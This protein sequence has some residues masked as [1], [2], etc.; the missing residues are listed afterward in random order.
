MLLGPTPNIAARC[1][2]RA[3]RARTRRTARWVSIA[4]ASGIARRASTSL[5]S[6]VGARVS[7]MPEFGSSA[8][9]YPLDPTSGRGWMRTDRRSESR[10]APVGARARSTVLVRPWPC[11][12][13]VGPIR[14]RHSTCPPLW[15]ANDPALTH[16]LGSASG[17]GRPVGRNALPSAQRPRARLRCSRR[18]RTVPKH[19]TPK[20]R[21]QL[22]PTRNRHLGR[23]RGV[24]GAD[25]VGVPSPL[26]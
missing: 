8:G 26:R 24:A 22:V 5:G 1:G 19:V 9:T 12:L 20:G 10:S 3:G 16:V 15:H 18:C 6:L 21:G 23:R 25:A 7:S 2:R 4:S 13:G 14:F 17:T 11:R